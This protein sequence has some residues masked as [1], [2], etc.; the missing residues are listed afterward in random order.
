MALSERCPWP[1]PQEYCPL[2]LL[3]AVQTRQI[4]KK[5]LGYV[6]VYSVQ[7]NPDKFCIK[8]HSKFYANLNA[9]SWAL[10]NKTKNQRMWIPPSLYM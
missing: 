7:K 5:D 3:E 2:D 10:K 9:A 6:L 1:Q 4:G 8:I